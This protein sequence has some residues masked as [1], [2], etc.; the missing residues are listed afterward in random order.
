MKKFKFIPFLFLVFSLT[1][2]SCSD[3][4][5]VSDDYKNDVLLKSVE[6]ED[7]TEVWEF[8]IVVDGEKINGEILLDWNHEKEVANSVIVSSN[9][10]DAIGISQ[11]EFDSQ[12]QTEVNSDDDDDPNDGLSPHAQC[13]E[14]CKDKYTDE[15]G[16]KIRGRGACKANCWVDTA[17]RLVEAIVPAL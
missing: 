16:N 5:T 6:N 4:E 11:S 1:Y 10:L 12:L 3:D 9:I 8:S 2:I 14:T 7:I 17:I 13:I 15:N